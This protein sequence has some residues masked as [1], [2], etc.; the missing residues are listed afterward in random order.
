[1]AN[2]KAVD[3]TLNE[4]PGTHRWIVT[5]IDQAIK[6]GFPNTREQKDG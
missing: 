2:W 1:M 5:M 6:E 4:M 3:V